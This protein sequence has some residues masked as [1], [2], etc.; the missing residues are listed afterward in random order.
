MYV[1]TSILSAPNL[2][3]KLLQGRAVER[4]PG[5]RPIVIVLG[6]QPPALVRLA[7][8]VGLA[9]FALRIE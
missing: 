6:Y 3:E 9:G 4:R 8:D 1:S 2:G 7:L 5:K